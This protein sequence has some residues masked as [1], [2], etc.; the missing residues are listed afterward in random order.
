MYSRLCQK[1]FDVMGA[2]REP[3]LRLSVESPGVGTASVAG[4]GRG[5]VI[6]TPADDDTIRA[7]GRRRGREKGQ[8]GAKE[9]TDAASQRGRE[10]LLWRRRRA[11]A[12]VRR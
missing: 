9:R 2:P 1:R 3:A 6:A 10:G 4:D 7:A 12:V 8:E 5:G 11:G